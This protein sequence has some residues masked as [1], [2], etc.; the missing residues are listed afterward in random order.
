VPAIELAGPSGVGKST[1]ANACRIAKSAPVSLTDA[2]SGIDASPFTNLLEQVAATAK[3]ERLEQRMSFLCRSL[4]RL[5]LARRSSEPVILDG[6]LIRRAHGVV[7]LRSDVPIE[8][9]FRLMP[10]ADVTVFLLA[11][12]ELIEA[13]NRQRGGDHDRSAEAAAAMATDEIAVK[14]LT[15]RNA[16]L[17]FLNAADPVERNAEALSEI[18]WSIQGHS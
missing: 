6:G 7:A 3:G 15:A 14:V 11:D 1:L 2:L 16:N 18:A 8:D 9:Y 17:R 13:R 4:W 12:R 5:I 10:M